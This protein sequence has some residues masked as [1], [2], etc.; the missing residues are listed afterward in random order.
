MG[1]GM[2]N[3][4]YSPGWFFKQKAVFTMLLSGFL[5]RI[6][7]TRKHS[8]QGLA[9]SGNG[10]GRTI[11]FEMNLHVPCGIAGITRNGSRWEGEVTTVSLNS[12]GAYLSVPSDCELEGDV[13]LLFKVPVPLRSLFEKRRFRLHAE[14][15]PSGAAGPVLLFQGRRLIYVAF[16]EPLRF[17]FKP[18]RDER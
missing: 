16:S 11:A 18:V 8:S 3:A 4:R 1:A 2:E 7:G 6:R 13:V 10:G 9:P 12:H 5:P 17:R 15:K 14:V